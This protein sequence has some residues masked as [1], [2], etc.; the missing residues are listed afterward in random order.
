M[1]ARTD[2]NLLYGILAVQLNFIDRDALISAMNGWVLDKDRPLGQILIDH[3]ALSG[4]HGAL[5]DALVEEHLKLHDGDPEKSLAA[6]EPGRATHERLVRIGDAENQASP[7]PLR[8]PETSFVP[9]AAPNLDEVC[10]P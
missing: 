4:T 7:A 3:K 1:K 8:R 2:R 9:T 6:L 5:L 10:P